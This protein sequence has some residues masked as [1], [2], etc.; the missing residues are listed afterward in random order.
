MATVLCCMRTLEMNE[1]FEKRHELGIKCMMIS[2][3]KVYNEDFPSGIWV[4][5]SADHISFWLQYYN[6]YNIDYILVDAALDI[7]RLCKEVFIHNVYMVYPAV[8]RYD[9]LIN[10]ELDNNIAVQKGYTTREQAKAEMW[11][12]QQWAESI[13]M[14]EDN[15]I[16][17]LVKLH[18]DE[19]AIDLINRDMSEYDDYY[20]EWN[21]D[22]W[23]PEEMPHL[24]GNDNA[25]TCNVC[26]RGISSYANHIANKDTRICLYC[27]RKIADV[28]NK[29]F[30]DTI[31]IEERELKKD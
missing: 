24:P 26:G 18:K 14:I 4:Q 21:S 12:E 3:G 28:W 25:Y 20:V 30:H 9:E 16:A 5:R 10:R 29:N 22:D 6:Q 15:V 31:T 27:A 13:K 17:P 23:D 8:S 11:T 19:F 2:G 1:I 7:L